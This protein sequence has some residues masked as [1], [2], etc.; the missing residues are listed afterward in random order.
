M[1]CA[2]CQVGS[3]HRRKEFR[4]LC[5]A[6]NGGKLEVRYPGGHSHV[7]IEGAYTK[8]SAEYVPQLAEHFAQIFAFALR[9]KASREA[10]IPDVRG[11]ESVAA[12]GLLFSGDWKVE[13]QWHWQHASHINLL[14]SHA[15]V[16][17]LRK[18]ATEGGN[19]R[20]TGLLDSRVAKGASARA[21]QPS[22]QKLAAVQMHWTF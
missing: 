20:F 15:Y 1:I 8:P 22:F 21:L 12:N 18:L 13:F 10:E 19:C 4:L 16:A 2:S 6:F 7:R 17:L 5:Y 3:I 14:E 11:V 9:Q